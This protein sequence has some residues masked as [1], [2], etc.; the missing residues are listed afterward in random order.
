MPERWHDIRS[1]DEGA[2]LDQPRSPTTAAESALLQRQFEAHTDPFAEPQWSRERVATKAGL[3]VLFHHRR[4]R[5]VNL[6]DSRPSREQQHEFA[7]GICADVGHQHRTPTLK[8][9]LGRIDIHREVHRHY[10]Y[11]TMLGLTLFVFRIGMRFGHVLVAVD[12]VTQGNPCHK[13]GRTYADDARSEPLP[14]SALIATDPSMRR[15]H[16]KH[17][18]GRPVQS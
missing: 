11:N 9:T 8:A 12:P 13:G 14:A 7:Y 2:V 16:E 6:P 17:R 10:L 1:L 5:D 15:Q 4:V 18:E 3:H